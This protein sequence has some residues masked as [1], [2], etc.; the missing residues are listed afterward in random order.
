MG[1][2]VAALCPET[3]SRNMGPHAKH[4]SSRSD[5]QSAESDT[6]GAGTH[7]LQLFDTRDSLAFSVSAFLAGADGS[8]GL[9]VLCTSV[10]WRAIAQAL[11]H[12]G[13]DDRAAALTG[14]LAVL[15]A[16]EVLGR[17]V[18]RGHPSRPLFRQSVGSLVSQLAA[19]WRA[20]LRVY[21][22]L[23]ELLARDGNYGA[24]ER[25]EAFWNELIARHPVRLLCGS[26]AA[27]FAAPDA[28]CALASIRAH[29]TATIAGAGDQ[30]GDFLLSHAH[31]AAL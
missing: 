28:G 2:K 19:R 29:H 17:I 23:V 13:F 12:R 27:H 21:G 16:E 11:A 1:A 20:G 4:A 7:V 22:E 5:R 25:V 24:A 15:D 14:R 30:L 9:L 3:V 18:R 8:Q 10:N 6:E 26:S 31:S